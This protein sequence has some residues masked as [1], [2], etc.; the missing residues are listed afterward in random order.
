[1][2]EIQGGGDR[3]PEIAF[4]EAILTARK[5]LDQSMPT[6]QAIEV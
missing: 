3:T 2:N 5:P 4:L 1:V 6:K